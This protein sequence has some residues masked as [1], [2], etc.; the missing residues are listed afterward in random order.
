MP[1]KKKSKLATKKKYAWKKCKNN[2]DE[3]TGM[4]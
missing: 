2:K 4:L 1:T 3:K